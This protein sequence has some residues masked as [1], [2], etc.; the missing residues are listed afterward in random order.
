[1]HTYS[2]FTC[3]VQNGSQWEW[4]YQHPGFTSITVGVVLQSSQWEWLCNYPSGS[5]FNPTGSG[6]IMVINAADVGGWGLLLSVMP[7]GDLCLVHQ[8]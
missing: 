5:G 2:T 6:F 1:M 4:L 8:F 7:L 3:V